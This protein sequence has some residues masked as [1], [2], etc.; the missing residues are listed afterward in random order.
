[1]EAT[2]H[3]PIR[4]ISWRDIAATYDARGLPFLR[5]YQEAGL[6][7]TRQR[8]SLTSTEPERSPR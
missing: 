4:P 3:H 8:A 1:M 2:M 5:Y 7:P 6:A